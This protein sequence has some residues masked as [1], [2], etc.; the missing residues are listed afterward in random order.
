MVAFHWFGVLLHVIGPPN[1]RMQ[2]TWLTGAPIHAGLG[3]P[4]RLRAARSRLTRHAA[5]AG[6]WAARNQTHTTAKSVF[7]SL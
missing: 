1:E 3:S 6:R 2:L 5:D 4:A 7:P